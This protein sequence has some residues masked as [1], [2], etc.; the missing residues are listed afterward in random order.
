MGVSQLVTEDD[1]VAPV[2][3]VALLVAIVVILASVVAVFVLDIGEE[4]QASPTAQF[5]FDYAQS[6]HNLTVTH[7]SGDSI[8]VTGLS[9]RGSGFNSSLPNHS[10]PISSVS[11]CESVPGLDMCEDGEWKGETTDT[12]AKGTAVIADDAVRVH[13]DDDYEIQ[14]VYQAPDTDTSAVLARDSGPDA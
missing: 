3:A 7:Q 6:E 11:A 12:R 4:T 14:L 2:V 1:A 10:P 13:V 5:G 9:V 8:R